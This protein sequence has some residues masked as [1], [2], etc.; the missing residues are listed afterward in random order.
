MRSYSDNAISKEQFEALENVAAT[1]FSNQE[2][3]KRKAR[4][5]VVLAY[6]SVI[7]ASISLGISIYSV[8]N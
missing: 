7:L 5:A 1:T 8:F 2:Y 3:V 4:I 6:A